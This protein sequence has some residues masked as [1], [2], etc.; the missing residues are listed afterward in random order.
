[1]KKYFNLVICIFILGCGPS[2]EFVKFDTN[3]RLAKSSDIDVFTDAT[4][5]NRPYKEIA[6]VTVD[7]KGHDYSE[8]ELL[9]LTISKAKELGADAIIVLTQDIQK[10]GGIFVGSVYVQANRRVVRATAIVYQEKNSP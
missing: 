6:L 10:G 8:V 4:K 5:I 7:D 1:M 9:K 2:V 3:S